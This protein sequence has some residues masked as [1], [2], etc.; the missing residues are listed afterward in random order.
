MNIITR[1]IATLRYP[2]STLGKTLHRILP[3]LLFVFL[4][5]TGFS[6][7]A[8]YCIIF[9]GRLGETIDPSSFLVRNYSAV[10]FAPAG[11]PP[12]EGWFIPSVHGAPVVFLCHGYKSN[13]AELLTLAS[14]F[15]ENGY[16]LFLFDFRGHGNSPSKLS[17][18]GIQETRDLLSAIDTIAAR[19]DVDPNR[20]GVWGVSLGAFVALSAATH[21]N[22][23]QTLVVDSPFESPEQFLEMQTSVVLGVDNWLIRRLSVLGFRL[24][25]LPNNQSEDALKLSLHNLQGKDKLF[26][27]S[28]EPNNLE[29]FTLNLFNLSPQP[30]ELLRMSHSRTSVL[31]DVDRKNYDNTVLE[32]FKRHLPLRLPHH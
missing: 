30:K 13:R 19:P 12:M 18:L 9:P 23:I 32:F 16:H 25:N 11:Q 20:V 28:E 21:S 31:Y 15:Q 7:F 27:T 6:W 14:T 10:Q 1:I 8:T 5:I 24:L 17:T 4:L 29:A 2:E 22:K 3:I 26:I